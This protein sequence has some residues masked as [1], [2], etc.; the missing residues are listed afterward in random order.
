MT[1][2]SSGDIFDMIT[3][4]Q[5]LWPLFLNI[6]PNTDVNIRLELSEHRSLNINEKV[7]LEGWVL[8][9]PTIVVPFPTCTW[10]NG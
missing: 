6:V 3:S 8:Y 5:S 2:T 4:H 10:A 9:I 7:I 1:M